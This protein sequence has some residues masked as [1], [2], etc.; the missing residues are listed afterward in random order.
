MFC[1]NCG[2]QVIEGY[3]YC[4]KCG[5]KIELKNKVINCQTND[6]KLVR[7]EKKSNFM[8]VSG[9]ILGITCILFYWILP[10]LPIVAI[11]SSSIGLSKINVESQK[12]R[13][14]GLIG[15]ILGILFTIQVLIKLFL[16]VGL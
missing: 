16:G 7:R 15:L 4:M 10:F 5:N 3:D 8:C 6:N 2:K 13:I 14:L 12:G 9:F 11:I 1:I